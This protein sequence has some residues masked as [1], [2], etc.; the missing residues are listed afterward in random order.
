MR[1]IRFLALAMVVVTITS[2]KKNPVENT[3]DQL[4]G[5]TDHGVMNP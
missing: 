5:K 3:A 4:K 1:V 2:C